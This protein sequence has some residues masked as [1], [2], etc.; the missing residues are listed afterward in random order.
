MLSTSLSCEQTHG[1]REGPVFEVL[2]VAQCWC[3]VYLIWPPQGQGELVIEFKTWRGADR[4]PP[5]ELASGRPIRRL[6]LAHA[7][8]AAYNIADPVEGFSDYGWFWGSIAKLH[9]R[10][11]HSVYIPALGKALKFSKEDIRTRVSVGES[12]LVHYRVIP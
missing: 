1:R 4:K 10:G 2:V 7:L 6:P 5:R 12:D 8:T 11:N 9:P 3:P